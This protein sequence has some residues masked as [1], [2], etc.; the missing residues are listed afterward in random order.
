LIKL[1][2]PGVEQFL[3]P[4]IART[5]LPSLT[6]DPLHALV[7]L[8][9]LA[10]AGFLSGSLANV[11]GGRWKQSL[12]TSVGG[13]LERY[14]AIESVETRRILGQVLHLLPFLSSEGAAF[15]PSV[16]AILDSLVI[17]SGSD[18]QAVQDDFKST[19]PWNSS[20]LLGA[21]LAA[22][23]AFDLSVGL[24]SGA[25]ADV[26][27]KLEKIVVMWSWNREVL[28]QVAGLAERWSD[29]QS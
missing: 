14:M 4:H 12:V 22:L 21:S 23:V 26:L 24:E 6:T 8:N 15:A 13:L 11:Q 16:V 5:I 9:N 2:W 17:N 27:D 18:A 7:L 1:R 19:G 29:E 20:H 28:E 25:R 3:I 10:E